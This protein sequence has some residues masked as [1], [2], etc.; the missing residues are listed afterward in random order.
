M[1][2][3]RSADAGG[4]KERQARAGGVSRRQVLRALVLGAVAAA[5]AP[6]E[7]ERLVERPQDVEPLARPEPEVGPAPG[8]PERSLL[9]RGGRV[10]D[11]EQRRDGVDVLVRDGW[12]REVAPGLE[13]EGQKSSA[14]THPYGR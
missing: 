1:V 2:C 11:G 8:A 13:A 5:C 12:I 3:S 4:P 14:T 9:I 10:F 7:V 6:G